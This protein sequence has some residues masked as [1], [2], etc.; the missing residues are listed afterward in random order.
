M[1]GNTVPPAFTPRKLPESLASQVFQLLRSAIHT[2]ALDPDTLYSIAQVAEQLEVSRSPVREAL[3]RMAETG[4]VQIVRNRGFV[5][6][7][8]HPREIAEIFAVRLALEVAAVE[9]V[10]RTANPVLGAHLRLAISE[11]H[12]AATRGDEEE[13]FRHD[14]LMHDGI[15]AAAGNERA[16]RIVAELRETI[17]ILG[18]YTA[19]QTRSLADIE[20]EHEPIVAA[21][22]AGQTL[23]AQE[24]MRAHL[25]HTSLLLIQ[26]ACAVHG[27]GETVLS[28]NGVAAARAIWAD[29]LG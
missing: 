20:R 22:E 5:V 10:S 13:F 2:G 4:I 23:P 26:Q 1:T 24:A 17:R 29:V 16:R 27:A 11:S 12:V 15:L 18:P 6:M 19:G 28:E 25:T 14:F 7:R 21:I 3:L 9:R 8:P